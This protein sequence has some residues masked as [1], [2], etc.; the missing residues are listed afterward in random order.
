V[1]I[2]PEA[3]RELQRRAKAHLRKQA[4]AVRGSMA[5]AAISA[6]STEIVRRLA[7]LPIVA[8]ADSVAL[9]YPM[10]GKNEVDLRPLDEL[11]RA[12]GARVAYPSI[13][14]DTR[15]M[16]FRFVVDPGAMEERGLGFSEPAATDEEARSL[17]IVVV[18]ALAVDMRG[19]RIG[20]GAGFYDRTLPKYA[21]P[22]HA[23]AVAFDFQLVAEVPA[24]EGDVRA[25]W[26]VTDARALAASDA[27][28]EP[29][30]LRDRRPA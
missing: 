29:A 10:E 1:E 2:D 3:L 18:P 13:D 5:K 28:A 7:E 6:R 26:I 15:E 25:E 23:V 14:P 17:S 19:H 20:Y 21:P 4:R 30:I 27:D 9:F 16:V 22:A 8:A 12:R 24:W 11:L